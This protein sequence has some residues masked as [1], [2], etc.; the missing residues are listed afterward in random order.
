MVEE[1][2]DQFGRKK[3]K[4]PVKQPVAPRQPPKP[5]VKPKERKHLEPVNREFKPE[6]QLG[7]T[8]TMN[9]ESIKASQICN[10]TSQNGFYCETCNCSMKDS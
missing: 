2:T 9:A 5:S 4:L 10:T 8:F 3:F 1:E 6:S 7:K